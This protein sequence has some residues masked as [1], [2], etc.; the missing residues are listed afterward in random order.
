[1]RTVLCTRTGRRVALLALVVGTAGA[2]ALPAA[3]A[4]NSP[5]TQHGSGHASTH[6]GGK[7]HAGDVG[8]IPPVKYVRDADGTIHQ[9]F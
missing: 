3:A 2:I 4:D 6:Q 5:A 7:Q 8:L 9:V 1:M